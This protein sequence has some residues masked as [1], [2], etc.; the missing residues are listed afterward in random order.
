MS[1]TTINVILYKS[2][3]LASGEHP[4]MLRVTQNRKVKY[5]SLGISCSAD[6]WDFKKGIPRKSHPNK[7]TIEA[8]I[9]SKKAEYKAKV[10]DLK[11]DKESFSSDELIEFVEKPVRHVTVITFLEEL[12]E[13]FISTGNIGNAK[14]HKDTK[15]V[16]NDYLN[17]KDI[18]FNRIDQSFLLKLETKL[19]KK[20][21]SEVS[22]SVYFRTIRAI[23]NK[24]I[25]E[26][27]V[28]PD[29]YPFT[30]YKISKF[31]TNTRKR[32]LSKDDIKKIES[33]DLPND[34]IY[35]L[36]RNCFLFSYY[37]SGINFIDIANLKWQNISDNRLFYKRSKTGKTINF[38][39]LEPA[40]RI[41]KSYEAITCFENE[42]YIFP[43]LDRKRHI[44]PQQ[45]A[46]RVQ[47]VIT[48]VN[49]GLK[50]IGK[51]AGITTPLTTYVARHTFATVLKRS[52][53]PTSVIS[54]AMGHNSELTTR[55]Y[56][57]SFDN[58]ILDEATM[59]L[60]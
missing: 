6:H 32:A 30:K 46:N 18:T 55:T 39:L 59:N 9:D 5:K 51:L 57:K 53:V 23:Y 34:Q 40:S 28:K 20:G 14:T 7:A 24:A 33:L 54:E 1:N 58:D 22:I 52:N 15:R 50:E 36:A 19:K 31:D 10:L 44:T 12:I 49:A 41:I 2:K 45:V 27:I 4:L 8:I 13:R 35:T 48:Q 47:K 26:N 21:L 25:Q 43:I 38:R 29:S 16:L 11:R 56:L 60:L 17:N 42:D 3:V 37:G